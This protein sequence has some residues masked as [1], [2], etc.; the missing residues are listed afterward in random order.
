MQHWAGAQHTNRQTGPAR[1]GAGGHAAK[2]SEAPG[3]C[4]HSGDAL[5]GTRPPL[6]ARYFS[7]S[8]SSAL[9]LPSRPGPVG[10]QGLLADLPCP[11]WQVSLP[12]TLTAPAAWGGVWPWA[13]D[14]RGWGTGAAQGMSRAASRATHRRQTPEHGLPCTR[15]RATATSGGLWRYR[16]GARHFLPREAHQK[17][18]RKA[19]RDPTPGRGVVCDQR[20]LSDWSKG[21]RVLRG[22]GMGLINTIGVLVGFLSLANVRG[23]TASVRL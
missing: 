9:E 14:G 5:P 22:A 8:A 12:R 16:G 20:A 1:A 10:C 18:H 4:R 19:R 7:R 13:C 17:T 2:Q 21:R 6:P 23:I 11:P 15:Q 3:V